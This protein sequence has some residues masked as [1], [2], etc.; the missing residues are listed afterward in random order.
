MERQYTEVI[1]GHRAEVAALGAPWRLCLG[2]EV[3]VMA[4]DDEKA[5]EAAALRWQDGMF[6][7]DPPGRLRRRDAM[8]RPLAG[9]SRVS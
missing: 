5:L 9:A 4:L 7:P 2:G 6:L 1:N 3:E 8:T